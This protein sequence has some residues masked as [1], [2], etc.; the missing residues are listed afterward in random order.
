[1]TVLKANVK[2][3]GVGRWEIK[4]NFRG[5]LTDIPGQAVATVKAGSGG[6]PA[7]GAIVDVDGMFR[8]VEGVFGTDGASGKHYVLLRRPAVWKFISSNSTG[9][10][11]GWQPELKAAIP[12]FRALPETKWTVSAASEASGAL[13]GQILAVEEPGVRV[14]PVIVDAVL[15]CDPTSR[16][17]EWAIEVALNRIGGTIGF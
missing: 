5:E 7:C 16:D 3:G 4:P 10:I 8:V 17:G 15:K 12:V 14:L 9:L 13:V 6:P 1:M 11:Q 2:P